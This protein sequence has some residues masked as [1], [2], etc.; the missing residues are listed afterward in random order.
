MNQEEF[1]EEFIL[2]DCREEAKKKLK[3]IIKKETNIALYGTI[4]GCL[5]GLITLKLM[6]II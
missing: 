1:L 3:H 5:L 2:N 4:T 6:G